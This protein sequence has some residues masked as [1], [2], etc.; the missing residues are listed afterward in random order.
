M[1]FGWKMS[2]ACC[3]SS[4]CCSGGSCHGASKLKSRMKIDN[5]VAQSM[6]KR[7]RG[8]DLWRLTAFTHGET[9]HVL[10]ETRSICHLPSDGSF[11]V[12]WILVG[13]VMLTKLLPKRG[14]LLSKSPI[15]AANGYHRFSSYPTL[16][17][18]Y[19][20]LWHSLPA[21]LNGTLWQFP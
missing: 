11:E 1:L 21:D 8:H 2:L 13:M 17:R 10:V 6:P 20:I 9:W 15:M 7:C 19:S 14:V 18:G 12:H 4:P 16:D 3:R 5:S